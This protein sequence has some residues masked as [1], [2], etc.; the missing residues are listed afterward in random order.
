MRGFWLTGQALALAVAISSIAAAGSASSQDP[1]TRSPRT[2]RINVNFHQTD[3]ADVVNTLSFQQSVNIALAP[4]VKGTVSLSLRN[5]TLEQ[6]LRLITRLVGLDYL[7]R[8]GTYLI[9]NPGELREIAAREGTRQTQPLA[10]LSS[11]DARSL[12]ATSCPYVTVRPLPA[13]QG[14]LLLGSAEDVAA[15]SRILREADRSVAVKPLAT[16]ALA[17]QRI[18]GEELRRVLA[19]VVPSL[20]TEQRG[21]VVLVSGTA[22]EIERAKKVL[23]AVDVAVAER[24]TTFVY[25]LKFISA[26]EAR[27]TLKQ[28]LPE[29][30]VAPS[31][32]PYGPPAAQ[33]N[34]LSTVAAAV[35]GMQGG[36]GSASGALTDT[37]GAGGPSAAPP[38]GGALQMKLSRASSVILVGTEGDVQQAR[39]ILERTDKPPPQVLI[40]A[41]VLELTPEA[42]KELGLSFPNPL[43]ETT[44]RERSTNGVKFGAFERSP[45]SIP[46][47]LNTLISRQLARVL[48]SPSITVVNNEDA[49]IFIGDLIKF[50]SSQTTD[51]QGRLQFTVDTQPVGITLLVRSRINADGAITLKL[52][53][54]VSTLTRNSAVTGAGNLP[55]VRSRE[56]DTTVRLQDGEMLAIGGLIS[57]E[58]VRAMERLPLLGDLPVIGK[59]FQ[60]R[61]SRRTRTDLTI[62]IRPRIIRPGEP[63]PQAGLM[64]E[65]GRS[66]GGAGEERKK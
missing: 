11:E 36:G 55:Q 38:G 43:I 56:A 2:N 25:D 42:T 3:I 32:A 6:A 54:V 59:L 65:V 30:V 29:L 46:L 4:N 19:R 12:V 35:S 60:H 64:G 62:L 31:P 1:R 57:E 23:A 44:I 39:S 24:K 9:G 15:A 66:S 58:E 18:A 49:S 37:G 61:F 7:Y 5:V 45:I 40:E 20:Q 41:Q 33:F 8:D 21:P 14:V 63:I 48:A 13:E 26:D 47:K 50:I 51:I 52:H 10:S 16:E 17:P 34:P 22:A 27:D 28:V 53:P